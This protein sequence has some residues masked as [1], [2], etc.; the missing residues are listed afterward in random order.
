MRKKFKI[1]IAVSFAL[2]LAN[3]SFSQG[4]A[5]NNDGTSADGSAMLDIKSTTSG[6]LIPRMNQSQRNLIASPATGLIIFQ[7][8]N[9]PGYYY[10]NGSGWQKLGTG[11]VESMTF[12]SPLTSTGGSTPTISIALANST[13]NGYLNSTDWNTFNNKLGTA[14]NSGR[15][16][17]GNGSN[18]ATGVAMTGDASLSNSGLLTVTA[19]QGRSVSATAPASG[20][21]LKWNGSS[22][23]PAAD[24]NSGGSVTSV[25]TGTGLTGGTITTTGTISLANTAVTPGSYGSS[26]Q[27]GTFTVD[28]Q[29]RLTSAGNVTISGVTPAAH[30]LDSHSNVTITGNTAGE[31]LKWNGSAWVNNTLAEAGIQPAGSYLTGNQTITLSGDVTGSGTTAITTTIADNSVDGTDIALGSDAQGDIMYYNGTDWARLGAGTSGQVLKTQGTG[32]NPVW[33]ADNNAGGT[34]TSIATN[35]GIT[36]GTITTTGTIGLTGQ[37]LALHNLATSGIIVRTGAATVAARTITAGNGITVT[38]GDGVSGNPTI[39]AN[40]G[41]TA[42]TVAEGNHTHTNMVTGTGTTNYLARWTSAS[43]LGTGAVQD[44]GSRV[45]I[46][47]SPHASYLAQIA[48]DVLLTSGWLRTTGST[49]WYSESYGGGWYM[50]DASWIRSYGSKGIYQN[51]GILRTDGNFQVGSSGST[52]NVPNGGDFS[53]RTSVLFANTAGNVGIGNNTPAEVLDVTGNVKA[54]GIVYWGNGLVRTESRDDAGL[55][56]DAGAK[57]G[58]YETSAPSPAANW[59]AGASSWWHLMDV[60]H[61]NNSNNYSMQFAGSFFD[62]NLYFRKTN[63]NAA[64]PWSKVMTSNDISG[65]TNYVAK[66]TGTNSIGNS[67]IFDNGTNVGVGTASPNEKLEVSGGTVR[68]SALAGTGNRPVTANAGGNLQYLENSTFTLSGNFSYSPDDLRSSWAH[69]GTAGG[70][71]TGDDTYVNATMPFSLV[72]E[73]VSYNTITI[74]TNGWVSFG[75]ISSSDRLNSSLPTSSFT[76]PVIFGYWDDLTTTDI[77]YGYVGTNPNMVYI[78]DYSAV[79]YSTGYAVNFQ[80]QIHQTS[81][82]INVKYRDAMNPYANGQ[83]ATIGFQTAGGS[84]SKA[85]PVTY[86][87]KVLDDNRDDAEGWSVCPVR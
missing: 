7:T 39:A 20:Q 81:G 26:T 70:T 80:I 62:Q 18:I 49:G 29:G 36:G 17:V 6:L 65:T 43:T 66:F 3:I 68:V 67:Q 79:T 78:I 84:S 69:G 31:I 23:T 12:N 53:Y 22:W 54:T 38:N 40:F 50:T 27:V 35:N 76:N 10:Y 24:N 21:I 28:A 33:A 73:G 48:G 52:L 11:N 8:D 44:N 64:Q 30:T 13:T 61:S 14:L 46:G 25:A 56:G 16:F 32:A 86:N 45:G 9:T 85:Y 55:R 34:V 60:R 77:R 5:I 87:G 51:T 41:T 2:F 42:S 19:I 83:S 63:N 72:I 74:C 75:T 59:P 58:F 37:A 4:V 1:V 57:S 82:L 71:L 15:I 47:T